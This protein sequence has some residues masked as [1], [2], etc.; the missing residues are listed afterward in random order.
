MQRFWKKKEPVL[1]FRLPEYPL[2]VLNISLPE[3][4][5]TLTAPS[6]QSLPP[7][8][9]QAA[10]IDSR[11]SITNKLL[12]LATASHHVIFPTEIYDRWQ[13][14][15]QSNWQARHETKNCSELAVQESDLNSGKLGDNLDVPLEYLCGISHMIMTTPVFDPRC[16]Q[17]KF[18]LSVIRW[19]LE[20]EKE[21]HPMTCQPLQVADLIVDETLKK[22]I[23]DYVESELSTHR[24]AKP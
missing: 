9:I 13:R 8:I 20:N 5:L 2:P 11:G 15:H 10:G 24:T 1:D 23:D 19:W 16:K 21:E 4:N 17:Q 7:A 3:T 14:Y 6:T 18:E 22:Q 12:S